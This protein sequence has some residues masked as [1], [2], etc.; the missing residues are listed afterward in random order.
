MLYKSKRKR[1][2]KGALVGTALCIAGLTMFSCSDTYDLDTE[3][4]SGLNTIY[5]YMKDQ[6]NFENVL[7]LIDDLGYTEVLSKT[8]SKTLFAANDDAFNEFYKNN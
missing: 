2:Y 8:G 7:H 4:P 3:Q 1:L 5:G 6:G